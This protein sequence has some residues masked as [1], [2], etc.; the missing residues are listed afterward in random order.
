M[1]PD[2][3]GCCYGGALRGLK[4][5]GVGSC[6]YNGG[7]GVVGAAGSCVA[8]LHGCLDAGTSTC[9][10]AG[11]KVFKSITEGRRARSDS[12][13]IYIR[14]GGPSLFAVMRV[15]RRLRR[16]FNGPMGVIQLHGGVGPVLLGR[17][18]ESKVCT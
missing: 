13:S 15:G 14:V 9:N 3:L 1:G 6:V 17:V 18:G 5:W 8:V 7:K 4:A 2:G 12:I 11:V 16:L 10:V